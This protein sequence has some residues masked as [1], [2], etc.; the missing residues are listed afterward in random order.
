MR[1]SSRAILHAFT[2]ALFVAA[3]GGCATH[4]ECL[5]SHPTAISDFYCCDFGDGYCKQT[6]SRSREVDTCDSFACEPGYAM[7]DDGNCVLG[8]PIANGRSPSVE[9][10][11]RVPPQPKG[12]RSN[13]PLMAGTG[14]L[15]VIGGA[16][17]F[18]GAAYLRYAESNPDPS[19]PFPVSHIGS[20]ALLGISGFFE[21]VGIPLTIAGF[22]PVEVYDSLSLRI[23]PPGAAA[24]ARF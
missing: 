24:T 16:G 23:G 17:G 3:V 9:R 8:G 21:L 5:S 20:S 11:N 15:M 18:A 14:L 4:R 22:W 10:S 7:D 6:C 2:A 1:T 13:S 12:T 19:D